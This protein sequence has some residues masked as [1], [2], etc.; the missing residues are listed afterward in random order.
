MVRGGQR[1]ASGRGPVEARIGDV[2]TCNPGEV[3]DGSPL[4]ERGRAWRMLYFAP[5][6]MFEAAGEPVG[7][8]DHS[9]VTVELGA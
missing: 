9:G 2:I 1:S 4:D 7:H 5:A 3:H 8:F 6:L